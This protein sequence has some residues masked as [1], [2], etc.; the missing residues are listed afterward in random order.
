M[1]KIEVIK[2]EAQDVI[3]ASVAIP[4][5]PLTPAT[6]IKPAECTCDPIVCDF[7]SVKDQFPGWGNPSFEVHDGCNA[8]THTCGH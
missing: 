6:P 7:A 3:T 2:F 5:I 4:M 1:L 8:S